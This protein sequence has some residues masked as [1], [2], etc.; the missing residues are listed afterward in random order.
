MNFE[1]LFLTIEEVLEIHGD[2][3]SLYGGSAGVRDEGLLKSALSQASTTF[4]GKLL[5][6]CLAS[7]AAAY[8]FHL[9]QNH[10]FIDGNK[11]VGLAC[12]IV[13]LEI[14]GYELDPW[15]D[16]VN[17]NTEKTHLE[18]LVLSVA[19]GEYSKDELQLFIQDHIKHTGGY[20]EP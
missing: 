2:Q 14:N 17:K 6:N 5:H 18:E 9:V 12:A 16:K 13:F 10:P 15:L 11:R 8:L 7:Q 4:D 3:I 20:E 1:P 19:T